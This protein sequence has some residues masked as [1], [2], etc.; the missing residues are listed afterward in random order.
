MLVDEKHRSLI[1]AFENA[2]CNVATIL[3]YGLG[4]I[5]GKPSHFG[6]LILTGMG[7]VTTSLLLYC[8]WIYLWPEKEHSHLND[9]NMNGHTHT[10]QD[11]DTKGT[12][13]HRHPVS[14]FGKSDATTTGYQQV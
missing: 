5:I 4:I 8:A 12:I 1:G 2:L 14:R 13:M 3:L 6:S 7:A 11:E 9:D 10:T